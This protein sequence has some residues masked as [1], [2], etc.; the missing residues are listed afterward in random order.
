MKDLGLQTSCDAERHLS[1]RRSHVWVP[2]ERW[3]GKRTRLKP[4]QRRL[5]VGAAALLL[6]TALLY[7]LHVSLLVG[8]ARWLDVEDPPARAALIYLFAGDLHSRPAL[9]AELYRRGYA[10]RIVVAREQTLP[11]VEMGVYPHRTDV[12]VRLLHRFGVPDSAIVVLQAPGG[13]TSTRDEAVLLA[14]WLRTHP[15]RRV[16]AVTSRY[17]TRRARWQ[18]R[19]AL[20]EDQ[21]ELRMA[22][23]DDPRFDERNWWRSEDGLIAYGNE[24][25][26]G[27]Q[28]V[29]LALSRSD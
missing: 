13:T 5:G 9:A 25:L 8:V 3:V 19:R 24:L 17:H 23:A 21:V 16:I 18:L 11:A 1:R 22:G 7:A 6:G 27:V 20:E 2:N 4:W 29:L 28:N 14:R 26:K 12:T 15:A 10:P